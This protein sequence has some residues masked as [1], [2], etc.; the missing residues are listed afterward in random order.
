V[1][2]H[3]SNRNL[4]LVGPAA[5]AAREA[6]ALVISGEHWV[7]PSVSHYV[8]TGGQVLLVS[9]D[10]AVID[11]YRDNPEWTTPKIGGRAWTDDYTNVWGAMIARL[12]GE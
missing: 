10:P 1:L 4:E 6:G 12:R 8:E 9:R 3:L 7:D 2:L 5:A 11:R